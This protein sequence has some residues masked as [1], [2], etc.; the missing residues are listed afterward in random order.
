[1]LPDVV[2]AMQ[3]LDSFALEQKDKRIVLTAVDYSKNA[4][5]MYAQMQSSLRKFFWRASHAM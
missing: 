3:L 2:L 5:E 1:M 4:D